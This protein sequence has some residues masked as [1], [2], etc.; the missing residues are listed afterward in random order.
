MVRDRL[1]KLIGIPTLGLSF[2]L[3]LDLFIF[4]DLS[5]QDL[6]FSILFFTTATFFIWKGS[7]F[8]VSSVRHGRLK[9]NSTAKLLTLSFSIALLA[10]ILSFTSLLI[11]EGYYNWHLSRSVYMNTTLICTMAMVI[12]ALIYEILFLNKERQIDSQIV[13][14]LDKELVQAEINVLR[15]ELD[16]HFVYNS[17]MPLYY[18]VKNDSRKAEAFA[19]KLIQVYQYFLQNRQNDFITLEEELKFIE[20]YFYLL[21]IRYKDQIQLSVHIEGSTEKIQI[22]PLSLQILIEN[23]IKH[24]EMD[25]NHPLQ[26][27]IRT[28]NEQMVVANNL[29]G[30]CREVSS[31]KIGLKNLRTRYKILTG[32]DISVIRNQEQFIVKLPLL[33]QANANDV[34]N[35]YRG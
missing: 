2:P 26:V 25:M 1:F 8:I 23:A 20:N 24:N 15:N 35:Y 3:S 30:K 17:L 12:S 18:L 5:L 32:M 9:N 4:H 34:N 14:H 28:E 13:H 33:S 22:L 10:M 29:Y 21:Q 11:W 19:C 7:V 16:P 31:S 6:A 27:S